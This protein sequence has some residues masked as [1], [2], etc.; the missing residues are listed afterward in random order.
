M[1]KNS[2]CVDSGVASAEMLGIPSSCFLMEG[3]MDLGQ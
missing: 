3:Q 2:G 1:K